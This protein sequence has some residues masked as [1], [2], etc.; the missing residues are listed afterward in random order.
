MLSDT[1]RTKYKPFRH[2][3]PRTPKKFWRAKTAED[4]CQ[5]NNNVRLLK[6]PRYN[7]GIQNSDGYG[8]GKYKPGNLVLQKKLP[9]VILVQDLKSIHPCNKSLFC[10]RKIPNVQLAGRL[11]NF[12]EN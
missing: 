5:E 8:Y 1:S 11:K 9:Y 12:I 3:L 2:G 4:F 7:N 10:A 6:K